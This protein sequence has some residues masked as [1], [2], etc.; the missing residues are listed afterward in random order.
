MQNPMQKFSQSFI[1][2]EKPGIL[3][4]TL[5]TLA[6]ANYPTVQYFLL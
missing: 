1:F 3:S 2:F 6:S 4:E 5:K